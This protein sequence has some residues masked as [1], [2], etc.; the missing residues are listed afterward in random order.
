MTFVS[1]FFYATI[2]LRF[3]CVVAV[4]ETHAFLRLNTIPLCGYT[5]ICLAIHPLMDIWLVSTFLL[6]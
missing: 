6:L 4:L 2:Y 5:R 3:I 1:S